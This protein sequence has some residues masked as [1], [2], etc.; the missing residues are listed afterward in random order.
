MSMN[1]KALV[2]LYKQIKK[3][4]IALSQAEEKTNRSHSEIV[5]IHNTIEILDYLVTLVLKDNAKW[6]KKG[7]ER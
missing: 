5:D 6:V 7:E 4:K 3:K 1:E 2:Y